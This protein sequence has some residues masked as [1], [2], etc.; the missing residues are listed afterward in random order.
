MG[1]APAEYRGRF[2]GFGLACTWLAG[3]GR[4]WDNPH[5]PLFQR[6]GLGS[7]VYAFVLSVALRLVVRPLKPRRWSCATCSSP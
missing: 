2:I 6:L 7:V 3:V 5:A 1:P 4:Y